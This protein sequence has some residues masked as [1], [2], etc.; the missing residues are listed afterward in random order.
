MSFNFSKTLDFPPHIKIDEK[1]LP[2]VSSSK[3]LGL[4]IQTDLR[5]TN[6][7]EYICKKARKRIWILRRMMQLGVDYTIILDVYYKEIRSILEYSA[8][9][10]H[11]SLT[12]KLSNDIESVQRL[13]MFLLTQYL[14]LKMSYMESCLLFSAESLHLRR[15]NLC[16]TFV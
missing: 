5:F 13:V 16:E 6:H 14:S 8:V 7:V 2:E 4:V 3:L 9:I 12:T 11:S 10:F 1:F 15:S